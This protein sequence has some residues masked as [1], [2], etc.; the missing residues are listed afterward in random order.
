MDGSGF[1][2]GLKG[3]QIMVEARIIAVADEVDELSVTRPMR[4]RTPGLEKALEAIAAGRGRA[5][6]PQVVDACLKVFKEGKYR[7]D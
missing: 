7:Y 4:P 6:D 5:Y 3:E 2:N 1:P